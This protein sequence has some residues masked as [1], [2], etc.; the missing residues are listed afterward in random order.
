MNLPTIIVAV[1]VSAI[2]LAIV[3]TS[4]RNKKQ[5]K[6]SCACGG[7]CSRCSHCQH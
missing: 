2:F 6:S 3:A 1:I 7:D 5:G 4:I